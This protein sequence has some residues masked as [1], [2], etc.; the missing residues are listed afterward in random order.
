MGSWGEEQNDPPEI[1][2]THPTQNRVRV[3]VL[4]DGT[5]ISHGESPSKEGE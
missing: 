3:R 4:R 1:A 5:F 2:G